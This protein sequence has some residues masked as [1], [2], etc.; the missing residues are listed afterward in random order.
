MNVFILLTLRKLYKEKKI[1]LY[2]YFYIFFISYPK[3]G[4]WDSSSV[5]STAEWA[6][7]PIDVSSLSFFFVC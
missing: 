5:S 1:V 6:K 3:F 4:I 7:G 2:L